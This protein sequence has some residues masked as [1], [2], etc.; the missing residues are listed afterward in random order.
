M[1]SSKGD[2]ISII[3]PIFGG[4]QYVTQC[5][6]SIL[7]QSHRNIEVILINDGSPDR[8]GEI[9]DHA[10]KLD[11][12]IRVVHKENAGLVSARKVGTSIATGKY[13]GFV[14]GDDWV[15]PDYFAKMFD[16]ME[17]SS[18]DLVVS[19]HKREFLGKQVTISPQ[20]D[21]GIYDRAEIE[22]NVLPIAIFN[23]VFFQ[24]GI[25]TYVWN[26]LFRREEAARHIRQIPE[27]IVVGED[28]C[29]TYPYLNSASRLVVTQ[30]GE[31]FYRQRP[32]SIL[33]SVQDSG[34]EY[35]RLSTLF[36]YLNR[37]FSDT[38]IEFNINEQLRKYFYA[39][40][41]LRSGGVIRSD[42]EEFWYS[43]FPRLADQKKI[44]IYSSG[45][46]GQLL[47]QALRRLGT[48]EIVGWIDEDV[49]ESRH[50]GLPVTSIQ[51]LCNLDFDLILVASVDEEYSALIASKLQQHGV[52]NTK[53][54]SVH[55]SF[56]ALAV[57]L[58]NIGFNLD[59]YDYYPPELNRSDF[60]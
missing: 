13:L 2:S 49:Q 30:E 28:A 9:C 6:D 60:G 24:H 35:S 46:F 20:I 16:L 50:V 36:K 3:V 10:A 58:T 23:G 15:G 4:E 52:E 8:S 43:P 14:D 1:S 31:Y 45:S 17:S 21:S 56:E 51:T 37:C 27:K 25:S 12:R 41:I 32:R 19:G 59:T 48:F 54:S 39:L 33:K 18:A 11:P 42:V 34:A 5:I 53:I 55:P 44:A 7:T 40:A 47:F 38:K 26:K 22:S 29:L 57:S